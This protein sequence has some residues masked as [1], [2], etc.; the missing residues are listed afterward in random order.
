MSFPVKSVAIIGAGPCGLALAKTLVAEQCFKKIQIFERQAQTGGVWNYY[1]NTRDTPLIPS[2]DPYQKEPPFL[3]DGKKVFFNPMYK[4]METNIPKEVMMYNNTPFD[5]SLPTFPLR[6]DVL[7]Y[8][9]KY[10]EPI[11][12]L[13]KLSTEVDSIEKVGQEWK[14]T[15]TTEGSAQETEEYDA[16]VVCTGHYDVPHLPNV[17]GIKEWA[18]RYPGSI[19]HSKYYNDPKDFA[20]QTVLVVGNSASGLDV[21]LQVA[22]HAKKV[23]RSINSESRMPYCEDPRVTDV[24]VIQEFNSAKHT[25]TLV[26]G[27]VF[28]D[29]DKII[30]CTGYL[31]SFPFLKSY[32]DPQ[33][34]DSIITTGNRLN[35]LYKQI[36]YYPDPT[37]SVIVMTKFTVPFPLAESQGAIVARVYAGRLDLPPPAAMR[38]SEQAEEQAK[39][40]GSDFHNFQFPKDAEY[41]NE[42]YDWMKRE[43]RPATNGEEVK[44]FEP[45]YMDEGKIAA[46]QGAYALKTARLEEKLKE[47]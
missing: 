27:T 21:S 40:S 23:Y 26:D 7:K 37:L 35:R 6:S 36:F 38:A 32:V 10:G 5:D 18:E 43:T 9:Q 44:G 45:A 29:I 33:N 3:R 15:Y 28:T 12:D 41:M 30:Y 8:V 14:V 4:D 20:D 16:I 11:K 2:T 1:P 17:K 22:T 46:R 39:G 24:A 31:Y 13:V 25:V 19:S 47:L 34:P 42:L